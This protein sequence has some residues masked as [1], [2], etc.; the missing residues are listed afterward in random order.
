MRS[1][2]PGLIA[3]GVVAYPLF[4]VATVPARY[5]AA[6][7]PPSAVAIEDARG[8]LWSGSARAVVAM[9]QGPVP[10]DRLEWHFRPL[11]LIAGRAAFDVHAVTR[12]MEARTQVERGP[13]ATHLVNLELRGDAAALAFLAPIV[14]AWQPQGTLSANAAS[15]TL[16]GGELR[17]EGRA[18]WLSAATTLSQVRPL[19]SYRAE[20]KAA[21]GPAKVVLTTMEGPLRLTGDGTLTAQGGFAFTGEAR[22]EGPAATDLEPLLNLMGPRRPDGSR[23]LRWS[24]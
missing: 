10:L 5:I 24:Q 2:T 17:G 3:L 23:T 7:L 4:L 14:A 19:G 8:T 18:E 21:G 15:L 9:P 6:R 1:R 13:G 20:L 22:A 16:D 11:R 12:G